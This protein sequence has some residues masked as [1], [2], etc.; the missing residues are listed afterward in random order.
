MKHCYRNC[1]RV[2][3]VWALKTWRKKI[4]WGEMPRFGY[5][6]N[7]PEVLRLKFPILTDKKPKIKGPQ[8]GW[9]RVKLKITVTPL[10]KDDIEQENDPGQ[11]IPT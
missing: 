3:Y 9:A 7:D 5:Y 2:Y 6:V 4:Q 10:D 8:A 1:P 11:T